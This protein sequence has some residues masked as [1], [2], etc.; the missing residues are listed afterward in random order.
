MTQ[1]QKQK[2][3]TIDILAVKVNGVKQ[4]LIE[5]KIKKH[6]LLRDL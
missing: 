5:N 6:L 2:L 1:T 3:Q 4:P